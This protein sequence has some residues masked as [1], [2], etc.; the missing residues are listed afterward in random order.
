MSSESYMNWL[1]Y[2]DQEG[3]FQEWLKEKKLEDAYEAWLFQKF[4]SEEADKAD[5]LYE[6]E[7]DTKMM[8]HWENET[9]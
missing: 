3:L 9:N 4:I 8:E 5:Y 2:K 6:Q 7:K 1:E